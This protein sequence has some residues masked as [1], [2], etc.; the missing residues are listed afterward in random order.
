[1]SL[2]ET[3]HQAKARP[4]PPFLTVSLDIARGLAALMVFCFHIS[5]LITAASP[6]LGRLASYGYMGVPIFFVISGYCMA[7]SAK[8]VLRK[9]RSAGSFLRKRFLRI[10]PP[11]WASI[12]VI[13][14]IPYL[15]AGL[16]ILKTGNYIWPTLGYA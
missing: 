1:M 3:Y 13:M 8:Q 9:N 4:A 15:L 14:A 16:S 11:F 6:T 10:Y 5:N 12:L 2:Q 7:A